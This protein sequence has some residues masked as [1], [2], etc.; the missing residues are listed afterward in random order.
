MRQ[1]DAFFALNGYTNAL[2][3]LMAGFTTI[4]DL[5]APNDAIFSLRDAINHGVVA[6]PKIIAAGQGISPTNEHGDSHGLKRAFLDAEPNDN[7]CDGADDC[8]RATRAAI[9]YGADVIKVHVTGGV[10]GPSDAGTEPQF[11]AEELK[12]LVE[13]GHSLGRKDHTHAPRKVGTDAARPARTHYT[14]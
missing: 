5:G 10:L 13:A 3:T 11:S 4:R 1:E 14:H 6:G 2:T 12:A 8:R 9:K 7:V